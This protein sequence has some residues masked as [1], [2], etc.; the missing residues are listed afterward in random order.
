[1]IKKIVGHDLVG[2]VV[3]VGLGVLFIWA[4]ADKILNPTAFAKIVN[5]YQILPGEVINVFAIILPWLEFICGLALVAGVF[6][7]PASAWIGWML[8]VFLVAVSVALLR[9]ININCGCFSTSSHA[10]TL[11]VTLLLQDF[12]ILIMAIHA[13]YFNN[14]F[15]SARRLFVKDKP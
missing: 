2:W 1:M 15:L 10:R 8:V 13:Y 6:V 3:R 12:G 9:G 4:S 11:G 14:R 7:R 5:N